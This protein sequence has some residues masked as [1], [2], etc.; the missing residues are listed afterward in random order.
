[1]AQDALVRKLFLTLHDSF[2]GKPAAP[3]ELLRYGLVT[4]ALADQVMHRRVGVDNRRIVL[5]GPRN[6]SDEVDSFVLASIRPEGV[7][8][9]RSWIE[10]CGRPLHERVARALVADGVVRHE[11]GGRRLVR[12]GP[13]RYPALDLLRAAGPRIR[14]EHMLRSP[15]D[16][17]L[18]GATMAGIIHGLGMDAVLDV[19]RDRA[20]VKQTAAAAAE[21][22]PTDL[23][24]LLEAVTAAV[25]E[26]TLTFRRL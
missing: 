23:R 5:T 9:T 10:A 17:D 3:P 2:S 24:L 12:R 16:M 14:L 8:L 11:A 25:S 4:A 19:E 15:H 22:L 6:G 26:V 1:M 21:Q 13:D 20:A 18:A 7:D